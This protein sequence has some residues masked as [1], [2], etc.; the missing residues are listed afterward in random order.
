[1]KKHFLFAM[2]LAIAL[3]SQ[4]AVR[5]KHWSLMAERMFPAVSSLQA[6][7]VPERLAAVLDTRKKRID[8]C[9]QA[10]KCLFLASTWNDEEMDAVAGAVAALPATPG[11]RPV[12]FDDGAKA[13]V[14]RE[15]RGLNAIL[16]T[17]GFG[18]E[19]RYPMIDGPVE[20]PGSEEFKVLVADALWLA[21]A[22]RN[23]PGVNLDPSI[24]LA[25]ALIDVNE[26]NDAVQF[27]PLDKGLNTAPFAL[28]RTIDWKRYKYTAIIIPGVGPENPA[29]SMSARGKLH[30]KV[31]ANRFAEGNT[32]FIVVSGAAV[33]PK[34]SH[35]VEA[36]EMR[37]QLI[38][39]YNVPADRIVIEPYAR[40]TTTNLRNVTRELAAMGAPIDKPTLIVA[41]PS[42]S[43][44]I[45]SPEFAARNP[46]ELGYHPGVVG[47]RLSPF[48]LEF[49][50]SLKSLRVD[51]WDPLDP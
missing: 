1:M 27:E 5:D 21:D 13:Q 23:D 14:V 50:P 20:K 7:K 39:R 10:S 12:V 34:G 44:Y 47:P 45:E 46:A 31:A 2:A 29:I 30:M 41:N 17:Y 32:A 43:R 26:R 25:I 37:K 36:V 8:A 22:G 16:Q 24:P 48:E 40:H 51:P 49:R 19:T 11:K 33:H 35:F 42:Q 18:N 15:L 9:Q 6:G 4:A 28:A 38:E 3:P